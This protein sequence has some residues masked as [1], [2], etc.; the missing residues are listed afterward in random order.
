M[1]TTIELTDNELA[2][3]Q[4][5]TRQSDPSAAVRTAMQEYLRYVRRMELKKLSGK[6]VMEDNWRELEEAELKDQH[7]R[8]ESDP[9]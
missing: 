5:A 4:Q 2:Q 7:G 9:D 3:L 6:V 8:I 1:T